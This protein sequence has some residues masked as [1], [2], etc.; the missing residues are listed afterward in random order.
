MGSSKNVL[1]SPEFGQNFEISGM[2]ILLLDQL[3]RTHV[4]STY[5]HI[6]IL[7]MHTYSYMLCKSVCRVI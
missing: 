1:G 3:L 6:Y 7:Y 4:L 5:I 2:K